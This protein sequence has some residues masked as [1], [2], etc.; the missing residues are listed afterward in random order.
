MNFKWLPFFAVLVV[1][2][3]ILLILLPLPNPPSIDDG[4]RH[5]VMGRTMAERGMLSVGGWGDFFSTGYFTQHNTDPWFL[6]DVLMMPLRGVPTV[7]A[8]KL[9]IV[10]SI[11]FFIATALFA[12]RSFRMSPAVTGALLLFLML[13]EPKFTGRLF[14]ARPFLL[15]T[16]I[17]IL[18]LLAVL[19]RK[20]VWVFILLAFATLLS[21]LFVLPLGIA[22][23]GAL[24]LRSL[25]EKRGALL[26]LVALIGGTGLGLLLHPAPLNYIHYLLTVFIRIPFSFSQRAEMGSEMF[27]SFASG[28]SLVE[29][30]AAVIFLMGLFAVV[31]LR[32]PRI[33][34]HRGGL[35]LI[36]VIAGSLLLASFLWVRAIDVLWPF[37]ILLL[38]GLLASVPQLPGAML[39]A[40]AP[41]S[42]LQT[43]R[44]VVLFLILICSARLYRLTELMGERNTHTSLQ[45]FAAVQIIPPNEA[46]LNLDWDIFPP[47]LSLRPDMM[48]AAGIDVNLTAFTDREAADLLALPDVWQKNPTLLPDDPSPWITALHAHLPGNYL[49]LATWRYPLLLPKLRTLPIL[50]ELA[51]GKDGLTVFKIIP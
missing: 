40:F 28:P 44:I 4:L 3:I 47:L 21:H 35:S 18:T 13:G 20:P 16:C 33:A 49:I 5:L 22:L 19:R 12:L 31:R 34:L 27:S 32:V 26:L 38:A 23:L 6:A 39:R 8:L 7:A 41:R 51:S 14:L 42:P 50:K 15:M 30:L 45:R 25:P 46:V 43:A 9:I 10:L 36:A 48:F 17:A 29:P 11:A 1:F 24:W 37:L 2:G